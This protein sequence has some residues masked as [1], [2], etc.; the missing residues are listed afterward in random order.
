MKIFFLVL[1]SII[2]LSF[3]LLIKN[4]IELIN[5]L[6]PLLKDI[7]KIESINSY[8]VGILNKILSILTNNGITLIKSSLNT[9]SNIILIIILHILELNHIY[10]VLIYTEI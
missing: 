4:G 6:I 3:P 5:Y 7:I 10:M 1:I 2:I 9:F 8:L